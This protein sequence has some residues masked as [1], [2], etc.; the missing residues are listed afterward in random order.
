[1]GVGQ[2]AET[3]LSIMNQ[4]NQISE[5]I[6]GLM[7]EKLSGEDM[8]EVQKMVGEL[9][10]EVRRAMFMDKWIED[11]VEKMIQQYLTAVRQMMIKWTYEDKQLFSNLEKLEKIHKSQ[12]SYCRWHWRFKGP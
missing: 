6:D 12:S 7:E 4:M 8:M 5:R 11:D 1:M 3:I 2:I 10:S 9:Q